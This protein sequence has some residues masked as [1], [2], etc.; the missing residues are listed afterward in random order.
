MQ[1][2][3]FQNNRYL[4]ALGWPL[5]NQYGTTTGTTAPYHL[6]THNTPTHQSLIQKYPNAKTE[7]P[8]HSVQFSPTPHR[9]P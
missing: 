4:K 6:N 5:Y 2:G 7:T 9:I 1:G 3:D 8:S